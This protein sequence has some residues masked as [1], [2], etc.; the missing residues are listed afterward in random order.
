MKSKNYS[1]VK[2]RTL[3]SFLKNKRLP[4]SLIKIDVEGDELNVLKGARETIR[5][6][7]PDIFIELHPWYINPL[8]I[9]DELKSH[10]YSVKT[11]KYNLYAC[12]S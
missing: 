5:K 9:I 10:G 6:N 11:F 7:L 4:V 8:K 3:D 2:T 1:L 12:C